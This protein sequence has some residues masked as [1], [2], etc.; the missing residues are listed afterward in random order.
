MTL[1]TQFRHL[2]Q[3]VALGARMEDGWR[4]CWVGGW[5]HCHLFFIVMVVR[6]LPD[7]PALA[8][9]PPIADPSPPQII[10]RIALRFRQIRVIHGVT[11]KSAKQGETIMTTYTINAK[12]AIVAFAT[13]EEAAASRATPFD[14]FRNAEELAQLATAWPPERLLA[15]WNGVD[16]L[17][18]AKEIKDAAKAAKLIFKRL[19]KQ[20][21]PA[22]EQQP[23]GENQA[24]G[25]AQSPKGTPPKA[26]ATQ[27][28]PA[29]KNSAKASKKASAAQAYGEGCPRE[30]R[31]S[32]N[33][34]SA[35]AEGPRDGSKM[36]Q[37][38]ALM[39]RKG[40]V[41]ISELMET[42]GWL[43]H[44]VRG[45]VAGALKKAGY[46]VESFKPEGGERTYRLCGAPHNR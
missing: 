13:P 46:T 26:K 18:P 6:P 3:P 32:N 17:A 37:A 29:A 5:D 44:T 35:K 40:G 36:A 14:S 22:R 38:I 25:V 11:A 20:G 39:Q 2:R 15:V 30:S 1:E 12:N 8:G 28:A 16:G 33:R 9:R 27:K 4:V 34:A 7:P 24:K 45:F 41:T 10:R 43:K 21:A 42:M 19:E 31:C 23:Q